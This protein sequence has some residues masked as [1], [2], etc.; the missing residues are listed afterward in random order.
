MRLLRKFAAG[1]ADDLCSG[2]RVNASL[3]FSPTINGMFPPWESGLGCRFPVLG[4][5]LT[6]WEVPCPK[7]PP[8]G[9]PRAG[10]AEVHPVGW[11]GSSALQWGHRSQGKVGWGHLGGSRAS[12]ARFGER[13]ENRGKGEKG[14]WKKPTLVD[15]SRWKASSVSARGWREE[16]DGQVQAHGDG[17]TSSV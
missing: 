13:K 1:Y 8:R 9:T 16:G 3:T 4:S 7:L 6:L 17:F 5:S 14:K 15:P 2:N 12:T 11:W 10:G